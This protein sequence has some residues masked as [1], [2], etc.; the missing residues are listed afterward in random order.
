MDVDLIYLDPPFN[1]NRNYNAIYNETGRLRPAQLNAFCNIW[2]L[3]DEQIVSFVRFGGIIVNMD[4][5]EEIGKTL[6]KLLF[7]YKGRVSRLTYWLYPVYSLGTWAFVGAM[8]ELLP[9]V[10]DYVL[11][12]LFGPLCLGLLYGF[13][14]LHVKR[15]HDTNRSG[16]NVYMCITPI[17]GQFYTF[18]V[19]GCFPSTKGINRFGEQPEE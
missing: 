9:S 17:I 6:F 5:I 3:D 8:V 4:Y 15:L 16:R 13:I 14:P 11:L 10:V 1:S 19:C 18:I 12:I 2:A 7:S